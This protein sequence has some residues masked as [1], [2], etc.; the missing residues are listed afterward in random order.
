M[1]TKKSIFGCDENKRQFFGGNLEFFVVGPIVTP[2]FFL[3][4]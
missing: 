1:K 4:I 2:F 3:S